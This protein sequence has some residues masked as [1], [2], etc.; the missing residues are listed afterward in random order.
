MLII[1]LEI[2]V[3]LMFVGGVFGVERVSSI[4]Y[5]IMKIILIRLVIIEKF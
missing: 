2:V 5:I 3:N 4:Y 1:L